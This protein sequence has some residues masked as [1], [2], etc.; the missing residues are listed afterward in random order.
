[1]ASPRQSRP[2]AGFNRVSSMSSSSSGQRGQPTFTRSTTRSTASGSY[3]ATT[4]T[5]RSEFQD[6][7]CEMAVAVG[8]P[9]ALPRSL[10]SLPSQRAAPSYASD[11]AGAEEYLMSLRPKRVLIGKSSKGFAKDEVLLAL[12]KAIGAKKST[13]LIEGLIQLA[14]TGGAS[15][16]NASGSFTTDKK[17]HAIPTLD[18]LFTQA[19]HSRSLDVWRLFL[20]R[21]SQRS[22]DASLAS[23]LK[24]RTEDTDRI[25]SLLEYGANPELCQ[26]RILDLIGLGLEALVEILML[27][28]LVNNVEFLSQGLVRAA[29]G[30]SVRN[31][32]IL[33]LRGADG[34]FG[35]ASALKSA[36]SAQRY[37]LALAIVTMA[38]TPVSSSNLDDGVSLIG[39][40][41]RE[42]QRPF[43]KMLLYAGASGPRSSKAILPFITSHDQDIISGLTECSAFRH[44]LFPAPRLFQYAI[45]TR[46]FTL[47]LDV[48]RSSNNRSFSD[49]ASTGV[50][51]QLIEGYAENAEESHKIISELLTLGAS[52]D[53]TSQM[54]VGCCA[55][56]QLEHPNI[57]SLITLLIGTAGAKVNYQDGKALLLAVEA[58]HPA[59]VSAL[60]AAKPTK[61]I[62]SSAVA[63]ANSVLSDSNPAKLEIL[64]TLINAGASGALVDQELLSAVDKSPQSMKRVKTL[65]RGASLDHGEGK[66]IV[67]AVQLERLDL[68]EAMFAQKTPQFMTFTSIWKQTRKLFAL[69]ESSNGQLPYSLAYMLRTFEIFH[70]SAKGATPVN[71]LLVDATKC[72]SSD[73]AL[74][75]SR[76]FLR[77]GATP[78]HALG[79]PLQ[80]CVKRSD[81]KTLAALLEVETSKTSIKYGFV[82][83]LALRHASRHE[84]LELIMGAGIEKAPL[85]AAL[86]QVLRENPYDSLTVSL[87]IGAGAT[88]HSSFG[89]N[90]VPPALNLDL[91]VIEN[92]LPSIPDNHSLLLPLKALLSSRK[93]WQRPDGESLPMVKLLVRNCGRGAWADGSF[94]TGVK[95]C[96]Q[97]FASIFTSHLTS[98]NVYSDALQEFLVLDSTP[99]NRET[100]SMTQ[101]LLRNGAKGNAIDNFFISAAR[102]L[103]LD[104]VMALYPHISDRSVA[105]SAFELVE[106]NKDSSATANGNRLEIVQFLLKQGLDGPM[107]NDAFVKT[108]ST[109]DV[110]GM[111]DYLPFVTLKDAFSESLDLLAQKG[112]LL[113]SREGLAAVELLINKGASSASIA[114]AARTA[115][116][117]LDLTATRMIIGMSR[118]HLVLHAAFLGA[119][120]H[121]QPLGTPGSRNILLYLLENGLGGEDTEQVTRLAAKTFDLS[122]V[123]ALAPLKNSR[124]LHDCAIDAIAFRNKAWL[125]ATGLEFVDYLV[126]KGIS[127]SATN[128]LIEAGSEALHLG[129]LRMLLPASEDKSKAVELA[130]GAVVSDSDRW[131]SSEGLHVVNFLLEYGAKGLA[132]EEAAS[133]AAETSNY[134]ALDVFLKSPAATSAIPAAFKALTRSKPGQLSSEQLTIA[135]TLVKQGVSTEII[136]VAAIEMAKILDIEG[137]KVLSGSPRFRQVTD[138]VLRTLL[139]EDRLW[140]TP[141]GNLITRFLI[142]KGASTKMV[143]AAASKAAMSLD[144][145]ALRNVFGSDSPFSVVESAITAMTGLEKGWLC[146][147]GL[148]IMDYLLQREPSEDSINKAFVQACQY[149]YFDAAKLLEPSVSDTAVLN[150]A[151]NRAVSTDS[152]WLSELHLIQ[153][154]LESGAQGDT[155]EVALIKGAHA[156][157]LA[158]L[159]LLSS[160]VD[161]PEVYSRALAAAIENTHQWRRC[162]DVIQFLLAHDAIG[163]PVDK[164]YLLASE[165]LDL[166]AIKLLYPYVNSADVHSKAFRAAASN[167]SW[168]SPNYLEVLETL[169]T[170]DIDSEVVGVALVAAAEA[171]NVAAVSLLS[172]NADETVC[173][174]AFTAAT[175]DIKKWTSEEG[176]KVIEIL[177]QKGAR[178]DA[179]D[180][181][182]ISSARLFRLD[183]ISI[184][185]HNIDRENFSCFSLALDALLSTHGSADTWVSNSDGLE[186]LQILVSMGASGDSAHGEY[187]DEGK[188]LYLPL[189][190][191]L[192]LPFRLLC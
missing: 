184:L 6:R 88:L 48:L 118:T 107:V 41:I 171:L 189:R 185:V 133:Y 180:D 87:I 138:N 190:R 57:M 66:A 166:P 8:V 90:L 32:S 115:S 68:L 135:S 60:T 97:H 36:I 109:A 2:P 45:D 112:D 111:N 131:T 150:E 176:T 35:Q 147:E 178:G 25:K 186:I 110:K 82:E 154:L 156:L 80:A 170:K 26:D 127:T 101:Y 17:G 169:H 100:L 160:K 187:S 141:E 53:H 21:V 40:W 23:A 103:Q 142:E 181:T 10:L 121:P 56:E 75:L 81:T 9:L 34:N 54:L 113:V 120:E 104:W 13:L 117:S 165:G 96:N 14:E 129:A 18:Y 1:M 64:S 84:I 58:A 168:N 73:I 99:L 128:K 157:D 173:T 69:A 24:E 149:L 49:Y 145:D 20:G 114:N 124:G 174:E 125:S 153:L 86:P 134:D 93:D 4:E 67:K 92:L 39:P 152:D 27:S 106:N 63:R 37:D 30:G 51:L 5:S 89:E 70:G 98:D 151:L 119:M 162:L 50:H 161:R 85:D 12:D 137:L 155:V 179:V 182:L 42:A 130:F 7:L 126:G 123:K 28:P 108:A 44:S 31:T 52:G 79:A 140:R 11:K 102:N 65:V 172:L 91:Q 62:L 43:L 16:G 3:S 55:P 38:A 77:W 78:N 146:P 61:K 76:L 122:F 29:T 192:H 148:R 188:T 105:L 94:I 47:A 183:L 143:E 46:N 19:E 191:L 95:S 71:D 74:S 116:K 164:A 59:A 177:A 83:A 159:E 144:I 167:E 136:A 72:A 163:D 139:S 132:V 175:R 15:A 33:L 158:S 22:L